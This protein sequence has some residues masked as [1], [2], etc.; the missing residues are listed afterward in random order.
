MKILIAEDEKTTQIAVKN[1][2]NQL[3]IECDCADNGLEAVE[4]CKKEVTYSFIIM[5]LYMPDMNG[6]QALEAIR[7]LNNGA[8]YKIYL[9]TGNEEFTEEEA[10]KNGFDGLCKKPLNKQKAEELVSKFK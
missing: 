5:D 1:I 8:D 10:I 3:N 7:A 9:L 4:F 2:F 6:Q